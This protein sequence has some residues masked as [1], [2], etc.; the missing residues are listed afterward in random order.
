MSLDD[1]VDIGIQIVNSLL[2]GDTNPAAETERA[3]M[4]PVP[5]FRFSVEIEGVSVGWF[6]ECGGLNVER[7]TYPYEEGGLNAYVHE[8]PGRV[9][10]THITLKRGLADEELWKWFAGKSDE[11]LHEGKVTYRNASI[12]LYNVDRSVAKRWNIDRSYPVK[13]SGPDFKSDGNQVA[14]ETLELVHHGI[15]LA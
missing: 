4:E 7:A 5:N 1:A 10:H 9:K 15:N 2:G 6:T 11:G 14:V 13:W 8:L 12:V 3:G